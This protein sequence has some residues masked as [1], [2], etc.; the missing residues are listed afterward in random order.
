MGRVRL[1]LD[2]PVIKAVATRAAVKIVSRTSRQTVN[3]AKTI[4]P[5]D[6]GRLANSIG[7]KMTVRPTSVRSLVGSRLKYAAAQNEGAA[8]HSIYPRR[9]KALA[10]YWEKRGVR[11]VLYSVRHPGN[12]TTGFLTIALHVAGQRNNFIVTRTKIG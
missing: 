3:E 6:T 10:F 5:R 11:V 4:A 8:P 7:E 9:K 1:D 2:H 12:P